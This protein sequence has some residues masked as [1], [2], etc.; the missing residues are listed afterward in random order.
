M[1]SLLELTQVSKRYARGSHTSRERIALRAVALEVAPREFVAVWGRRRSGRT[2]LLEVCAGLEAPSQ[3]TVRFAGRDLAER[4]ML[5]VQEGIGFA[6]PHFSRMHGVVVEQ[7]ATP[8]LKTNVRV[9]SAQ[10]RAY[11]LLDRVGAVECAELLTEELEASELVRVMLARAL[12]MRPRLVLLDAPTSGVL[13]PERD[14]IFALLRSLTREDGIAI[15]MTVDVVPGL[16]TVADRLLSIGNGEL[17]GETRPPEPAA[18][19]PL[20]RTEPPA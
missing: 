14:E 10:M 9:E 5:G 11:E 4:R 20:R 1:S 2:T 16:A 12:V 3:G 18:V 6:Q 13:A 15:L 17:R 8:L 7:V 19:L